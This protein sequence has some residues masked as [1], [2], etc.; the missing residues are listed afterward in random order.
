VELLSG[1]AI[2]F[3]IL[4]PMYL[5]CSGKVDGLPIFPMMA[6]TYFVGFALP[7]FQQLESLRSFSDDVLLQGTLTTCAFLAIS[8]A[9]WFRCV[10]APTE[11]PSTYL[12][13]AVGGKPT[14]FLVTFLVGLVIQVCLA[15]GLLPRLSNGVYSLL[16]SISLSLI[17][18]S[19]TVLSDRW[20]RKALSGGA[21]FLFVFLLVTY[22][23]VVLPGL[24]IGAALT[25]VLLAVA[26]FT[27][28][29]GRLPIALLVGVFFVF[30]LL[31]MGKWP[32]R[33]QASRGKLEKPGFL[34]Y[35]AF[36]SRWFGYGF[37]ALVGASEGPVK[38]DKK[39]SGLLARSSLMQMVMLVQSKSPAEVPHMMGSTYAVIPELLIPRVLLEDKASSLESTYLLCIHY[40]LQDRQST[41]KTTIAF[42]MVAE[43][44][45]N[46][47]YPGVMAL[48]VLLGW[49]L[50]LGTRRSIN[51]PLTSFRGLVGLLLMSLAISLETTASVVICSFVQAFVVLSC[52]AALTMKEQSSLEI[53]QPEHDE[54]AAEETS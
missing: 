15:Q 13:F 18:L 49:V 51:L 20:G 12:G 42:G 4:R 2:G 48:A 23:M 30:T 54:S 1:V 53:L 24:L 37:S 31:H 40:G 28:S 41:R 34:D 43:A 32:L 16:R 7:M 47:S 6:L 50:A 52:F 33:E 22:L 44:Y 9:V 35:P 5:W 39:A 46:F 10:N 19:I 29:R 26:S 27:L 38:K 21:R 25:L 14:L 45:A 17:L 11:V 3:L 8:T 36:Y